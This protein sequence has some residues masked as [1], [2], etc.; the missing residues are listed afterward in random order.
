MM[1]GVCFAGLFAYTTK[2]QADLQRSKDLVADTQRQADALAIFEQQQQTL[3]ARQEIVTRA[4]A[5][6]V[7]MG[8]L[9]EE[10]S[11][12]LPDAIWLVDLQ[13]HEDSGLTM[14]GYTPES[15]KN[16]FDNSYKSIAAALVRVN[17]LEGFKDVWLSKADSATFSS[18]QGSNSVGQGAVKVVDFIISGKIVK[19][20]EISASEGMNTSSAPATS[21]VPTTGTISD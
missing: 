19:K 15:S 3:D 17:S 12:V 13:L 10:L 5:D 21:T 14:H 4:L 18:F 8:K 20:S 9:M 16:V 7:E 11:Y 1:V 6:R 2:Q